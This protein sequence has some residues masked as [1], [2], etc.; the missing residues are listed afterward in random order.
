MCA[1]PSGSMAIWA[2][3]T[4]GTTTPY[5][6]KDSSVPL[7]DKTAFYVTGDGQLIA[8]K[9]NITGTITAEDGKIGGWKIDK[10]DLY[11]GSSLSSALV[12]SSA[13]LW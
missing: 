3:Y 5:T 9:A 12:I 6:Y 2:G 11:Y 7:K 10:N 1:A 8:S 13:L 4:G